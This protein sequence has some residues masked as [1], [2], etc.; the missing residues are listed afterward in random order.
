[1]P[2]VYLPGPAPA[3]TV[4]NTW[5]TL[6]G[7]ERYG[8][9]YQGQMVKGTLPAGT[10]E[11]GLYCILFKVDISSCILMKKINSENILESAFSFLISCYWKNRLLCREMLK[12]ISF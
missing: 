4:A 12:K 9:L 1:M 11:R 5:Y 2:C 10:E 3:V 8:T 7:T 6:P